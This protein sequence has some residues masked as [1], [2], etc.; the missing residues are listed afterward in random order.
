MVSE[1]EVAE[2]N[3]YLRNRLNESK[4]IWAT[5]GKE[6]RLASLN[7]RATQSPATWRQ[8][9]GVPLMLHEIGH[10][11]NR[12]FMIG[13]GVSALAALWIQTKFTDE[14]RESSPYWSQ[15]HLKKGAGGHH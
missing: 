15:F 2:I 9:K 12:P 8:L 4:K 6:A 11:G 13:F 10:V 3:T 1:S 7:A 5:R 14:M